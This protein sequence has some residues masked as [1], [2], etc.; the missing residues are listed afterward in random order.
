MSNHHQ[1]VANQVVAAFRKLLEP[2]EQE[3]IGEVRFRE[4]HLMV[5]HALSTELESVTDRVERLVQEL[6][7][8][9]EKPELEL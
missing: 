2:A 1:E 9:V 3:L 6:R 5:C 4:L 8:E 7:K